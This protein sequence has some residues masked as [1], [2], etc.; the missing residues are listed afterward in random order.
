LGSKASL[1]RK[2]GNDTESKGADELS[3]KESRVVERL[4]S[5]SFASLYPGKVGDALTESSKE[6]SVGRGAITRGGSWEWFKRRGGKG[7]KGFSEW[8]EDEGK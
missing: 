2:V 3:N 7:I 1:P 5:P 4:D 8:V 6:C